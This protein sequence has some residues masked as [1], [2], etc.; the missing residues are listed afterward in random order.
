MCMV[1]RS[2]CSSSCYKN[3]TAF[4]RLALLNNNNDNDNNNNII[5]FKK[6]FISLN[7]NYSN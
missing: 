3:C 5:F 7:K 6:K 2:G 4:D 1:G